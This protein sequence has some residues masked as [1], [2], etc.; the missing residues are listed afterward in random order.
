[1]TRRA[2]TGRWWARLRVDGK[3]LSLGCA[4]TP[5]EAEALIVAAKKRIA[6][7]EAALD[8]ALAAPA[9]RSFVY[10]MQE[11][12][13]GGAIKIGRAANPVKRLLTLQTGTPRPLRLLCVIPGGARLEV[14]MHAAFAASRMN[15][16]WFEP[17]PD[18]LALIAEISQGKTIE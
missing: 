1:M 15:G 13:A 2:A 7:G 17:T 9:F 16:E 5:E 3:R 8:A 6:D 14:T 18:M 12:V 4:E 11:D 10:F